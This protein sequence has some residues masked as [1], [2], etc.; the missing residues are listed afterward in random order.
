MTPDE[1][2]AC[3]WMGSVE[4]VTTTK[5]EGTRLFMGGYAIHRNYYGEETHRTETTWNGVMECHDMKTADNMEA[6]LP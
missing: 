3:P 5:R 2:R 4:L 6:L 1:I